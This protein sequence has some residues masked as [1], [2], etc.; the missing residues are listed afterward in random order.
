MSG[1]AESYR[2]HLEL[3]SAAAAACG[4]PGQVRLVAV[5]KTFP[6][7]ALREAYAAGAREFGES[8][9]QELEAK[10]AALPA[11]VVW[12]LIGHLQANKVRPAVRRA[13]WI[14]SVDSVE[15]LRRI[16]RIAGEEGRSP[17]LL[18]EVNVSGEASKHGLTPAAA[19]AAGEAVAACAHGRVVGFMTMAPY[20]AGETEL[21]RVFGGLR[22]LR[23]AAERSWGRPLP[24]LSMGMSGDFG[25]AIAEGATL[26]RIGTAIFGGRTACLPP[27]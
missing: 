2:R 21:Q 17:R 8:R 3:V 25:I 27:A 16:D 15:L 10:A 6:E 4:R 23:E 14:H 26:V 1:V 22:Q 20:E 19:L 9:L 18:L 13:A 7:P 11:D 5:S 24:E 12:H